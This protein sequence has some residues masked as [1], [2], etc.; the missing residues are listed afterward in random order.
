MKTTL[1]ITVLTLLLGGCG[2]VE[3]VTQR[4]TLEQTPAYSS[5]YSQGCG[6]GYAASGHP[7]AEAKKDVNRYLSDPLYTTGWDDGFATCKGQCD[8]TYA[9]FK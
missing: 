1:G 6:A 5:G 7:Y 3:S 9:S 8:N 2:G 4:N